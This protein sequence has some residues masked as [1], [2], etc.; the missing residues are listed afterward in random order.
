MTM[1]TYQAKAI[2]VQEW[3]VFIA[4][5]LQGPISTNDN[6]ENNSNVIFNLEED[7]IVYEGLRFDRSSEDYFNELNQEEVDFVLVAKINNSVFYSKG[8]KDIVIYNIFN[9]RMKNIIETIAST[10]VVESFEDWLD[11]MENTDWDYYGT[12]PISWVL[13]LMRMTNSEILAELKKYAK[14]NESEAYEKGF[15]PDNEGVDV[16]EWSST[17]YDYFIKE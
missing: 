4:D 8:L 17:L 3:G 14:D 10:F 6:N 11:D 16:R 7:Y 13:S 12:D 1:T 5:F 15:L 9:N 2:Q